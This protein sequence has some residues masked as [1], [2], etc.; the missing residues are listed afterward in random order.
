MFL[1]EARLGAR[2]NHPNI[3]QTHEVGFDA[4]RPYLVM[5]Y[6]DGRSLH[7]IQRQLVGQGGL[8]VGAHLRALSQALLGLDYAH[9]LRGFDGTPLRVVHRDVSPLN[10]VLTFDGQTKVIDFGVAK[11]SDSQVETRTGVLKGRLAYMAP[12]QARGGEVDRRADIYAFGVMLWEAAAGR[13][14][15]PQLADTEILSRAQRGE[16]A[17]SLRSVCPDAPP[18]LN[19]ICARA[20]AQDPDD[21]HPTAAAL[22]ADLERHLAR[23]TDVPRMSDVGALIARAFDWERRRMNALIEREHTRAP[24]TPGSAWLPTLQG[25]LAAS[26]GTS[27]AVDPSDE[28]TPVSAVL[29]ST[30]PSLHS[31]AFAC[32]I[33]IPSP[34]THGVGLRFPFQDAPFA[35]KAGAIAVVGLSAL[36]VAVPSLASWA[37]AARPS[38]SNASPGE[39]SGPFAWPE[40]TRAI[41]TGPAPGSDPALAPSSSRGVDVAGGAASPGDDGAR[42]PERPIRVL[43]ESD[44]VEP[45]AA[46]NALTALP[47]RRMASTGKT[48]SPSLPATSL[49]APEVTET[50]RSERSPGATQGIP[51]GPARRGPSRPIVTRN[52]YGAP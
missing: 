29:P 47:S 46:D 22:L 38:T 19:A 18:D 33:P 41:E 17:P 34:S 40:E 26:P 4:E 48:S 50:P 14:L 45:G 27:A 24:S 44:R 39:P 8:P 10:V 23:R 12:E 2:L 11:G 7:R 9:G 32:S 6:L 37:C 36:I 15:W 25:R 13:R 3:V 51:H 43:S 28:P 20:L 52:P 16:P 31:Q 35:T 21:R 30:S 5:E 49:V 42:V 1:E